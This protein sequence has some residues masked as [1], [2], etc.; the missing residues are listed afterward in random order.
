MARIASTTDSPLRPGVSAILEQ[1]ARR[2]LPKTRR[3]QNSV[4]LDSIHLSPVQADPNRVPRP[5]SMNSGRESFSQVLEAASE[6]RTGRSVGER[7]ADSAAGSRTED[8]APEARPEERAP[9]SPTPQDTADRETPSRADGS[10]ATASPVS[11]ADVARRDAASATPSRSTERRAGPQPELQGKGSP[12]PAAPPSPTSG[13]PADAAGT[14]P[15]AAANLVGTSVATAPNARGPVGADPTTGVARLHGGTE[16]TGKAALRTGSATPGFRTYSP[17]LLHA[18]EHAR[19]SIFRQIAFRVT[20][21][22]SEMRVMLDPPELGQ[23][24]MNLVLDKAGV[25]QLS[26]QTERPELAVLLE[27]HMGEL[28]KALAAQGID[29]GRAQV[30]TRAGHQDPQQS[31]ADG[32]IRRPH[33]ASHDDITD[34]EAWIRQGYINADGLDY[35]V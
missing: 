2:L 33:D 3:N 30:E 21:D 15:V 26:I 19:D 5:A 17:Q 16:A 12:N 31:A 22:R 35:W 8:P 23:M 20:G 29:I 25:M 14:A 28:Q 10:D 11:A 7:D 24:D 1:M 6:D 34:P 4:V 32:D 9:R 18:A 27:K 13:R